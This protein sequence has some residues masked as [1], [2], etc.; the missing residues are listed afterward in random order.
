M[1][2]FLPAGIYVMIVEFCA[3]VIASSLWAAIRG[4][5]PVEAV[6]FGNTSGKVQFDLVKE[7]N[8]AREFEEFVAKLCASIRGE[9][10]STSTDIQLTTDEA[11]DLSQPH[12]Y[13][14]I[15]SLIVGSLWLEISHLHFFEKAGGA[16]FFIGFSVSLLGVGLC[17]G[18][19]MRSEKMRYLSLLGAA[20]TFVRLILH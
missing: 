3:M 17:V 8:Q 11:V 1:L 19:F 15:F 14:C 4:I 20:L 13:L 10:G 5:A 18:S 6:I 2:S 12:S 9:V 16:D 7:K